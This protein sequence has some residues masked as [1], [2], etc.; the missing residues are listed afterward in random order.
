MAV[1]VAA[2]A[3]SGVDDLA[4]PL[5]W[6]E[7]EDAATRAARGDRAMWLARHGWPESGW[8]FFGD[9][10]IIGPW[11]ELRRTFINGEYLATIL[12]SIEGG[13]LAGELLWAPAGDRVTSVPSLI[14][15]VASAAAVSSIQGSP[16]GRRWSLCS[17]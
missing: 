16:K 2:Y 4:D 13:H 10:G 8:I 14:R 7:E 6:L 9:L 11:D 3:C 1:G 15:D 17:T 12:D 5:E